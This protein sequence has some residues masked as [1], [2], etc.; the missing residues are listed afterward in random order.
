MTLFYLT[1][2]KLDIYL[3]NWVCVSVCV[4]AQVCVCMHVGVYVT[5]RTRKQAWFG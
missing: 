5:M 4:C 3:C 2:N 1:V